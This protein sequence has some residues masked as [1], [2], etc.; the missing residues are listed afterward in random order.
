[1]FGLSH[2]GFAI[3]KRSLT[4]AS[5]K[6]LK[7]DLTL[8]PFCQPT[9]EVFLRPKPVQFFH[10][11][12]ETIYIPRQFG[13]TRVAKKTP[14]PF[15]DIGQ[16]Q[17][18]QGIH[19]QGTLQEL[20]LFSQHDAC[21]RSISDLQTRGGSLL[22]LPTGTGK[23]ACALYILS[24]I[25]VKTAVIVHKE[26]LLT[27][28]KERIAHFLPA[29]QVGTIQGSIVDVDGKD[30][31][32]IMLQSVCQ[33]H[34]FPSR[35]PPETFQ[36]FGMVIM[37]ECH[38]LSARV[39]SQVF[40]LLTRPY[41]LGLSA[42]LQRKDKTEESLQWFIGPI[43][44]EVKMMNNDVEVRTVYYSET[45]DFAELPLNRMGKLNF[46]GL[47]T[48]ITNIEKRNNLIISIVDQEVRNGR[49]IIVMSD[50]RDHCKNLQERME[51]ENGIPGLLLIGGEMPTTE[52]INEC[53]LFFATF[54]LAAEGLDIPKL[55]C[56]ILATP[57]ADVVQATGR[58]MRNP[59]NQLRP[60]LI[61]D[62]VDHCGPMFAQ[63]CKRKAFYNTSGFSFNNSI[64]KS[65]SSSDG[66]FSRGSAANSFVTI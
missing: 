46:S 15:E 55:D 30:I 29:A 9:T 26:P 57:K 27:Q 49:N 64:Q 14:P 10:E 18:L 4:E 36:Q 61:I 63:Y 65:Q 59:G 19:F 5:L 12:E 53:N 51:K 24:Q 32:I 45:E 16:V 2:R 22:S 44:I 7:S 20:P 52:Q 8:Q 50:R 1:M 33:M 21:S 31:V 23:T 60:P 13:A 58:I 41:M 42:T 48:L 34:R 39:F 17:H 28:W 62:I 47:V 56:L 54:S 11:Y 3:R 37:D 35:C 43:S 38:H 6:K 25:S 40:H 66:S